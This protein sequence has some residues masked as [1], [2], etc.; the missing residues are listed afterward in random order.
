MDHYKDWGFY[1]RKTET[2]RVLIREMTA[3]L[4]FIK[5]ILTTG[6]ETTGEGQ[7]EALLPTLQ[8]WTDSQALVPGFSSSLE[9]FG[10]DYF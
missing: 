2:R 9:G 5:A 4:G 3:S 8:S 7:R 10:K 1:A 6:V